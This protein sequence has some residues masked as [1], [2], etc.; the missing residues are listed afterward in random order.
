MIYVFP[1]FT[2]LPTYLPTYLSAGSTDVGKWRPTK[3]GNLPG[4]APLWGQVKPWLLTS[5]T[6]FRLPPPPTLDSSI[7]LSS[8]LKGKKKSMH[9]CPSIYV[10]IYRIY[11]PT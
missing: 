11:L 8:Y 4:N 5:P 3:P 7:Y 1:L 9:E 6:Q 2:L 10:P